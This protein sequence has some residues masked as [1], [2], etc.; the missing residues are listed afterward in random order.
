MQTTVQLI[1]T[2]LQIGAVYVLFSLGLTLIFGVLRVVN[3]VH[4][5]FFALSAVLVS[6]FLPWLAGAGWPAL[7]AYLAAATGAMAVSVLLALAVYQLG[8]NR[9]V[10]DMEGVFIFTMGL[11]L[12]LDGLFLAVFGG[13]ARSVTPILEGNVLVLG[14]SVAL[15]RLMIC[16][17]AAL[18]TL[19]LWWMLSATRM[20]R[21][22]RAV[23]ADHEA[24]ML[25]GIPYRRIALLSFLLAALLAAFAGVLIAPV[26]VV[27]PMMGA[28]YLLKTF[29][30][31]VVGGLGSVPGAIAGALFIGMIESVGGYFFDASSA[32]LAVFVLVIVVLLVRPRGLLGRA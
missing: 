12:V 15:Q 27:T 25:Q 17:V 20:G 29:I 21:A 7:P 2:A 8:I 10:R 28:D 3:F 5:H 23:A 19:A 30:A 14:A 13:A 26:S 18:V 9:F 16:G 22:F 31:V 1:V 11:A 24:A 6:I 4:G 32:T